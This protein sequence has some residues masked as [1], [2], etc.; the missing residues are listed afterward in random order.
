LRHVAELEA[1]LAGAVPPEVPTVV[2]ADVNDR[3]GSPTWS[4]LAER[5]QDAF[6]VAGSGPAGTFPAA[7]PSRTIDGIFVGAGLT[8]RSARVVDHPD[9]ARA[10]DHRPLLAELDL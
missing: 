5:R 3:P 9:V 8:V 2:A 10:S 6:A 7:R 4:A 1:A